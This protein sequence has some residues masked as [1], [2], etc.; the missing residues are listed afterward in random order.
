MKEIILDIQRLTS[1]QKVIKLR[2]LCKLAGVSYV[3]ISAKV[4]HQR[5]L[6]VYESIALKTAMES[7]GV[8]FIGKPD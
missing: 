7:I 4:R 1:L 2:P 3:K 6:T 8:L 5:Q